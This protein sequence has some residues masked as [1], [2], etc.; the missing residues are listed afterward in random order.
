[1]LTKI[2]TTTTAIAPT[3]KAAVYEGIEKIRNNINIKQKSN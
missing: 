3:M 1:M 2:L